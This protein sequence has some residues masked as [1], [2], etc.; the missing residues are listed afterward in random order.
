MQPVEMFLFSPPFECII[1]RH[2]YAWAPAGVGKGDT[3]KMPKGYIRFS[4]H[5]LVCTKRT[6][7]SPP[8]PLCPQP[9]NPGYA[10]DKCSKFIV[11]RL[12]RQLAVVE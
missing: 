9:P 8:D 3:W 10:T 1:D 5:V 7:M 4:Y 6:K 12:M 11:H 2:I